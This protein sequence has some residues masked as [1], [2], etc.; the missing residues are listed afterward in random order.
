MVDTWVGYLLRA[1]ENMGLMDS[2]A[3]IFTSDHGFYFGEHDGLFG[4]L[5]FAKRLDGSLYRHGDADAVW[6][7]SP[8]YEEIVLV[9]LLVYVPGADPGVYRGL[10]S[11]VDVMPTVLDVMR[12]EVPGWVEGQSLLPKVHDPSLPGRDFAVSTV[13]FANPGDSV[14]SVD[15]IRRR[16]GRAPVTTVTTDEWSLLY[17]IDAGMSQLYHLPSDAGQGADLIGCQPEVA[18]DVHERLMKFMADTRL[19]QP[20]SGPRSELRL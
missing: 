9:P 13:P 12:K 14:D 16:L 11:A 4:K 18:R 20:L 6:D 17:S 8:L 1:V 15:N 7:F 5:T 2:T 10:S 19:P 3:I